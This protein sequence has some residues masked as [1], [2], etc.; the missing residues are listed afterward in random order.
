MS[1]LYIIEKR[2]LDQMVEWVEL[3]TETMRD[4]RNR[5]GLSYEGA[6]RAIPVSSKTW[7]RWEKRGAVPRYHLAKVAELLEIQI[8]TEPPATVKLSEGGQPSQLDRIEAAL[9]DLTDAVL[10]GD[11]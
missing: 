10:K 7:E 4:A 5:L 8:E 2:R 6:S 1:E 9:R 3:G 11:T